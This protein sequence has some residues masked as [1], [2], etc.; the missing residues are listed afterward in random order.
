MGHVSPSQTSTFQDLSKDIRNASIQLSFDPYNCP[1][2]IRESIGTPTPKMGVYLGVW[3]FIPSHS[4]ALWEHEMW[5]LG[6]ILA[7]TFANPYFIREPKARVATNK[8][9]MLE[10][11]N[12]KNQFTL[13]WKRYK[14]RL[15]LFFVIL[16]LIIF[17]FRK[18]C[19]HVMLWIMMCKLGI[20]FH[21]I[22]LG[23]VNLIV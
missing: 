8:L 10:D 4:F 2:K 1:L 17:L 12:E 23:M 5:L 20:R 11:S 7:R 21:C 6:S 16:T 18:K 13:L 3:R 22:Q 9:N 15:F 14:W 19:K